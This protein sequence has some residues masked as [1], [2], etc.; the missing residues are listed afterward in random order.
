MQAA[1]QRVQQLPAS[2]PTPKRIM[3][4]TGSCLIKVLESFVM[5]T[6]NNKALATPSTPL[7]HQA[8]GVH[9]SDTPDQ[10]EPTARFPY[11][12]HGNIDGGMHCIVLA[13]AL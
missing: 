1:S 4:L 11:R 5:L 2:S 7:D 12:D 13:A 3:P 8:M 9:V 10:V 6:A